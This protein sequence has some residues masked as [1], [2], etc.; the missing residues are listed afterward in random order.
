MFS[1]RLA[2]RF[3]ELKEL[4]G[5]SIVDYHSHPDTFR[6]AAHFPQKLLALDRFVEIIDFKGNVRY[7]LDKLR[8]GAIF[9]EAHPLDAVR[10][11]LKPGDMDLQVRK[12]FF[13]RSGRRG[14]NSDMVIPPTFSRDGGQLVGFANH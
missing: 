10:T 4:D 8:D 12:I 13:G 2:R 3:L 14:W 6:R 5:R 1:L 7:S 11:R 9:V